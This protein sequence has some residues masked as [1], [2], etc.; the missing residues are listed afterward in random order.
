MIAVA[1]R[2]EPRGAGEWPD[3]RAREGPSL[4]AP[5]APPGRPPDPQPRTGKDRHGSQRT[6]ERSPSQSPET[7]PVCGIYD[8]SAL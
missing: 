6:P 8:L 1:R 2:Q 3:R 5:G 4:I 7:Q